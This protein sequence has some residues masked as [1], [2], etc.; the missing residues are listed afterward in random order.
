MRIGAGCTGLLKR[1]NGC[2]APQHPTGSARRSGCTQ[3]AESE[4]GALLLLTQR[5]AQAAVR[6][7]TAPRRDSRAAGK[8]S[9]ALQT[10]AGVSVTHSDFRVAAAIRSGVVL[11]EHFPEQLR[12]RIAWHSAQR[13]AARSLRKGRREVALNSLITQLSSF[14]RTRSRRLW[15]RS[16]LP[17][18]G[19]WNQPAV[20]SEPS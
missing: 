1:G 4:W 19:P 10:L 5:A 3:L 17:S 6:A 16:P 7:E 9:P 11:P 18:H 12:Q 2:C 15:L 20:L 8:A 14:P 13:P